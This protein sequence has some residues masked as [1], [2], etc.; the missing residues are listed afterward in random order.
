MSPNNHE[1]GLVLDS[2]D[3]EVANTIQALLYDKFS[4]EGTGAGTFSQ[5]PVPEN[6]GTLVL[7]EN[8]ARRIA[9]HAHQA[10][11]QVMNQYQ[12]KDK[13]M[14]SLMDAGLFH[15]D[16]YKIL[17]IILPQLEDRVKKF[18]TFA[19]SAEVCISES[20]SYFTVA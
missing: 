6:E 20:Q 1:V 3:V 16:E 15:T 8:D 11:D 14:D 5:L 13:K 10:H 4:S 7:D 9:I 2:A 17:E 18:A 12:L 19:T